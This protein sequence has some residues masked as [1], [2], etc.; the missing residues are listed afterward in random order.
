MTANHDEERGAEADPDVTLHDPSLHI[1]RETSWLMFNA[2]VLAE[3]MA[4]H[5]PLLERL[6]FIAIHGANLD[7][8]FMIRVSGLHEQLEAAVVELSPDG[9]TVVEQLR[10][11]REI[12][13]D[14]LNTVREA[15]TDHVLPGLKQQGVEIVEWDGL[16]AET[17]DKANRYFRTTVFPILTP[18]AVDPGHPFPFLSN[19]SLSLAVEIRDPDTQERKFARVKVPEGLPRFVPLDT[20]DKRASLTTARFLPL[21]Q[22]IEANLPQLFP[23]LEILG[24][25]PFRVTRDM[26]F[27]ILA[28][29]A[30]DL[31]SIIDRELRKRRFGACVRLEI[32]RDIPPH[33]RLML[34]EKL[35]I[36]QEDLYETSGLLG[37]AQLLPIALLERPD[38]RDPPFVPRVPAQLADPE[39][40]SIFNA[41]RADELLLHHPYDSFMPVLDFLNQAAVDPQVLAV[42]LTLYRGGSN[43]DAARALIRAAENGK[44]VAVAIELKA[45]F[46]EENNIAWARSLERAGAHVFYGQAGM[47]THC[48]VA[49]VVRREADSIRRYVHLS[50]GNYNAST[51]RL[52]TDLGFMTCDPELGDDVSELFNSLSGFGKQTRYRKLAVAP[53]G[54]RDAII[55]HIEHEEQLARRGEPARIFAKMNSLVDVRVIHALYRASMAGVTVELVVRGVCCLRPGLPGISHNIRV[56]SIIGRFLEH[57]RAFVF[58]VEGREKFF[59]SSADWMPRNFN[60]RV[61]V[62]FPIEAEKLRE[63]IR[64][65]VVEPALRPETR[66]YE[67][68]SDGC[69]ERVPKDGSGLCSQTWVLDHAASDPTRRPLVL[70]RTSTLP[71][72]AIRTIH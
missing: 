53:T 37:L 70:L 60:E 46:D 51:A 43:A 35:E 58:G 52:Y 67:L 10:R 6:K 7:E 19:L 47:K 66:A 29:E 39:G 17:R 16:D 63:Q 15:L 61:E 12:I 24:A 20:A 11:I 27:E 23:E 62:L 4:P 22:L 2:R 71:P 56:R 25:Y 26:D 8:F 69:Y 9:L 38:L 48:K 50:T 57:P 45:R 28:E 41:I 18:L 1:N 42:K 49:L 31:M 36:D 3:A 68:R 65:E 30:V 34:L 13:L 32:D 55:S 21:E 64:R 5:N 33:I 59:L 54:L 40:S 14:Q 72:P 44:Q